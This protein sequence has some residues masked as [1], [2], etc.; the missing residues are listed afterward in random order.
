MQNFVDWAGGVPL[1]DF[2]RVLLGVQEVC[3]ILDD[4]LRAPAAVVERSNRESSSIL[5]YGSR[6]VFFTW[7]WRFLEYEYELEPN[8]GAQADLQKSEM[9]MKLTGLG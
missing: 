2:S 1:I 5:G 3:W 4:R 9:D 6:Q 8:V 7:Q